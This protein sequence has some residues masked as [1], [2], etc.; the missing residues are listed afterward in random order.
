MSWLGHATR[1]ARVDLLRMVRTHA[2]WKRGIGGAFSLLVSVVVI[3]GLTVGGGYAAFRLSGLL[4]DP[5]GD[6]GRLARDAGI[7]VVGGILALF[8]L[9]VAV[10]FLVR[11][12]GAR[13]TL[14]QPAGTLTVVPTREAF[15]GTLLAE[16]VYFQLW[17][18]GP[19]IGVGVGLALGLDVG[20]P[21]VAI[22][23][24]TSGLGVVGVSVGYPVGIGVRHLFS[25]F[26]FVARNKGA[27]LVAV[28]AGY[29]LLVMTGTL[30]QVVVG[31]FEPMQASPLAWF[32]HVA[33]LGIPLFPTDPL[34][35]AGAIAVSIAVFLVAVPGGTRVADRH[36]FSD[37]ALAGEET[38]AVRTETPGRG[39]ERYLS[40][41]VGPK[42]A[43]L[44][45]LAWRRASRSPLKLLYAMYPLF[46]LAGAFADIVQT[47]AVPSYLPYLMVLVVAWGAG[48][49]FTLNPLGDQ[50]AG[51]STTLLSRVD[52]RTF[53]HAHLLA[54]LAIAVP[55]GIV[56]TAV[57]GLLSP[58][59][60]P[61]V[62]IL[63]AATPV[64]MLVSAVLSIGIGMAFPKFEATNVTRSMRTVLPSMMGFLLFSLHL[65]LTAL[66]AGIV[67][68]PL[69]QELAAAVL[70]FVLPFGLTVSTQ[71]LYWIA[72][73][74]LVP[75]A[76]APL[77]AYRYATK[78]FD[79]YTIA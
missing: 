28:F 50:G 25:R 36:W 46:F 39:V 24:A 52:G 18:L 41:V 2:D 10:I 35:A 73:V 20:W 40:P 31:L 68:E 44:V 3:L 42:T 53:V 47:G 45:T 60:R 19:S 58:V 74:V 21:A 8:A 5:D 49:V 9:I 34:L 71:G 27:I 17:V 77:P 22:P 67:A 65:F 16:F 66:L 38:P 59:P 23:L 69:V 7:D 33:L 37:P 78:R 79:R 64:V 14:D 4:A 32:A 61:T 12:L 11:A 72:A 63:V 75:L 57:T 26:P 29:F 48:V 56:V 13:G 62:A 1:I 76:L 30:N 55:L 51:L 54:S 70:S 15:L 43:A 6:L